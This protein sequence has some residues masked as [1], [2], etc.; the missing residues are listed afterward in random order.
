M[1]SYPTLAVVAVGVIHDTQS[2]CVVHTCWIAHLDCTRIGERRCNIGIKRDVSAYFDV[3]CLRVNTS[4]EAS[5][6]WIRE[7]RIEN[8]ESRIENRESRIDNR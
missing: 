7:S 1:T 8:R 3:C 5:Q 6:M 4:N 2:Q